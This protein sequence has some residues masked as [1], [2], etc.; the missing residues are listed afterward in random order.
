ME[1][2][3]QRE[4][5]NAELLTARVRTGDIGSGDDTRRAK[6]REL[7]VEFF[8]SKPLNGSWETTAGPLRDKGIVPYS[9]LQMRTQRM[10]VFS[11]EKEKATL[12]LKR[13]IYSLIDSG[14]LQ[15][16]TE[17]FARNTNLGLHIRGKAYLCMSLPQDE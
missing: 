4:R 2:A 8:T 5:Q 16:M 3:I 9:W 13:T 11:S 10:P 7:I 14:D 15:E 12:A 6:L 17:E 1:W